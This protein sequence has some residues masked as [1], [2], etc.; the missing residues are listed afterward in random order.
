MRP[1][2]SEKKGE[3]LIRSAESRLG[4]IESLSSACVGV[5][6]AY[7]RLR[8][9]GTYAKVGLAAGGGLLG[10]L[11]L[12]R[13]LSRGGSRAAVVT[14]AKATPGSPLATV[15]VQALTVLV[16]PLLRERLL[17]GDW[18]ESLRK[19]RPSRFFFRWLGLEK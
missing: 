12:R 18:G 14:A 4:V 17:G 7:A 15:F 3:I 10:M 6:R 13:L 1:T 2:V 5:E 16:F 8:T 11:L 9:P 19:I